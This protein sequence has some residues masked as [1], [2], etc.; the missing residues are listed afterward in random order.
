MKSAMSISSQP[1]T[2][3]A[4]NTLWEAQRDYRKR[5]LISLTRDLDLAEDLMSDTYLLAH[6]GWDGFR[7][8]DARA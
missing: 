1:A 8:G 3:S 5:L 6:S 4:W 7:G 2:T